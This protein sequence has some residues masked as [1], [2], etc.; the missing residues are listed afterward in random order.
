MPL[1]EEERAETTAARELCEALNER[2]EVLKVIYRRAM[3]LSVMRGDW[4]PRVAFRGKNRDINDDYLLSIYRKAVQDNPDVPPMVV[5]NLPGESAGR[6]RL[7]RHVCAMV[8]L[9]VLL[10]RLVVPG[11][12]Q[13]PWSVG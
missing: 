8:P 10:E 4:N 6:R 1:T 3:E 2:P 7:V 5:W 13:S 11:A 9:T 12:E